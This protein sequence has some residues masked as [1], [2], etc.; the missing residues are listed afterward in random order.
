[1]KKFSFLLIICAV[2]FTS[3]NYG[4]EITNM[5]NLT[6]SEVEGIKIN[7]EP[8]SSNKTSYSIAELKN[9]FTSEQDII[10]LNDIYNT[11]VIEYLRKI[12]NLDSY[13]IVFPVSEGGKFV[14]F[15]YHN[16]DLKTG[17]KKLCYSDYMYVFNL[18]DE[19]M[20]EFVDNS[21]TYEDIKSIAPCTQLITT[22]SSS[23]ESYSLLKNGSVMM[24]T[25]VRAEEQSLRVNT[26]MMIS[27]DDYRF[28]Y[29]GMIPSDLVE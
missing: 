27:K 19:K 9:F 23:V 8:I 7:N 17:Q 15:L 1:M 16:L 12:E 26:T 2:I 28:P 10:Y 14:V 29:E 20:F 6:T 21:Y 13:Y 11:F 4:K 18:P 5:S 24:C 3:C 25:Y 22:K